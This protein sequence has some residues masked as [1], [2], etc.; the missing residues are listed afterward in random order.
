[1]TTHQYFLQN[2]FT[3]FTDSKSAVFELKKLYPTNTIAK[4]ILDEISKRKQNNY[5]FVWIPSHSGI[6]GNE[7]A[8]VLAKKSLELK[9]DKKL[10]L[11][12]EDGKAVLKTNVWNSWKE[13]WKNSEIKT[14]RKI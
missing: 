10:I 14:L 3:I 5:I 1:M 4:E 8:D 9:I 7:K 12:N 13:I 6:P 2:V 11:T